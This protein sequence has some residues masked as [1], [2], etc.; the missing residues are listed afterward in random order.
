LFLHYAPHLVHDPYELP[1]ADLDKFNFIAKSQAGDMKGLRQ[2]YAGMVNY[3]D[4]VVGN[5]TTEMKEMG[6][7]ENTLLVFASD[8]GG[9]IQGGQGANNS[10]LRGG[11]LTEWEGGIRVSSFLSGGFLPQSARGTKL[12]M[13]MHVS[14][15][16]ATLA[17]AV[18]IHSSKGGSSG[19]ADDPVAAAVGLPAVDSISFWQ[20]AIGANTTAARAELLINGVYYDNTGLKLFGGAGDAI[21]TGEFYPNAS[22]DYSANSKTHSS[23]SK[24][25]CL[26]DVGG[27]DPGEHVDLAPARPQD[28]A[29]MSARVDEIRK[30]EKGF[31]PSR[32]N[33]DPRACSAID[34]YGG[35]FGPW[36]E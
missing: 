31:K 26:F 2:V 9:P 1:Q 36:I 14:D 23:C 6:M 30:S 35:F 15:I 25:G 8:N 29:R 5:I 34:S 27:A 17:E 19:P 32:G 13:L 24:S 3:L 10:P 7:W 11:K 12:N 16:W 21:W 22:T 28:V 4:R 18:G 33:Q 20:Q